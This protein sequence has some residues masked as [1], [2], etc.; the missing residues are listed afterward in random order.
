MLR[1]PPRSTRTDTLFPYTTLFRSSPAPRHNRGAVHLIDWLLADHR[2]DMVLKAG[3]PV[4][5]A[6]VLP[7]LL[8]CFV[9]VTRGLLEIRNDFA[10]LAPL[11]DRIATFPPLSAQGYQIVRASCGDRVCE[12]V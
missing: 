4:G 11:G 3:N 6:P 12:Y 9:T 2:K 8:Q 10:G 1:R 7:A 5:M